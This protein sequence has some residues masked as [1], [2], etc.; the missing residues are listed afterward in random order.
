MH[1]GNR[2]NLQLFTDSRTLF[3]VISKERKLSVTRLML[4]AVAERESFRNMEISDTSFIRSSNNIA[5]GLTK[6]MC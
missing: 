2:V 1:C 3:D 5:N 4:D 6:S